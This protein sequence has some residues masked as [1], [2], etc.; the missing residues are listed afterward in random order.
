MEPLKRFSRRTRRTAR[1]VAAGREK[2][3]KSQLAGEICSLVRQRAPGGRGQK[4]STRI[5]GAAGPA[6]RMAGT[7]SSAR[8]LTEPISP[9]ASRQNTC[10][11]NC[12]NEIWGGC[13]ASI[14]GSRHFAVRRVG[15]H[16]QREYQ[17]GYVLPADHLPWQR[18]DDPTPRSNRTRCRFAG[19]TEAFTFEH[20]GI[21]CEAAP[22]FG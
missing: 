2:I 11:I 15:P 10:A 8:R 20:W 1:P 14:P 5:R 17:P 3:A 21:A 18:H 22:H 7:F 19:R 4:L 6:L 13:I 16:D 12:S 9:P